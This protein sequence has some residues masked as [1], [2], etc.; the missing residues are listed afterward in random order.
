ML[1]PNMQSLQATFRGEL[2][3]PADSGYN[4]ARQ[5]WNASVNKHPALIARCVGVA[6][7]IA[8]VDFAR[9]NPYLTYASSEHAIAASDFPR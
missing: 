1:L 4:E 5:I 8:A 2:F 7:V 6:D 9:E 3:E